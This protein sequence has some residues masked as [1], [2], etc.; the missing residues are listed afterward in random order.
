MPELYEVRSGLCG[1]E[2]FFFRI[3]LDIVTENSGTLEERR[4]RSFAVS[5]VLCAGCL[6]FIPI[7][8]KSS[9]VPKS[10]NLKNSYIKGEQWQ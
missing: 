3:V 5:A 9:A 1:N 2:P 6:C 7:K 4:H 10:E 8:L